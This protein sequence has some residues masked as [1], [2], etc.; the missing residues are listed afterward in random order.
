MLLFG[1]LW[2]ALEVI[3][4]PGQQPGGAQSSKECW[5][6]AAGS[7]EASPR[8]IRT[9]PVTNHL[10]HTLVIFAVAEAGRGAH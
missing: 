5:L 9:D 3:A 10:D 7:A 4:Q 1:L 2:K 8:I 6:Q